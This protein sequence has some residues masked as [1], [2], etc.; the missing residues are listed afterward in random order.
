MIKII[1]N[2]NFGYVNYNK[3]IKMVRPNTSLNRRNN[4]I[5]RDLQSQ[6]SQMSLTSSDTGGSAT[7]STSSSSDTGSSSASASTSSSSDTAGSASASTSSSSDTGGSASAST[8]SSSD[9]GG[10]ASASTSTSSDTASLTCSWTSLRFTG[11]IPNIHPSSIMAIAYSPDGRYVVTDASDRKLRIWRASS[12]R[13][14]TAGL[15][16]EI[17]KENSYSSMHSLSFSGD[18]TKMIFINNDYHNSNNTVEI[19]DI[20]GRASTWQLSRSLNHEFYRVYACALNHDGSIAATASQ[21]MNIRIWNA[22]TGD[23]IRVIEGHINKINCV[24][25]ILNDRYIVSAGL[26]RDIMMWEVET[27]YHFTH[28]RGHTDAVTCLKVNRDGTRLFS[29]S[30]DTTIRMWSLERVPG[31][32]LYTFDCV[33]ILRHHLHFVYALVCNPHFDFVV[34]TSK[35]GTVK[36]WNLS[37]NQLIRT[38]S[39]LNHDHHAMAMSPDGRMILT[40]GIDGSLHAFS[41]DAYLIISGA[42]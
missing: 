1:S 33:G 23:L 5:I 21:D 3:T 19:Y 15:V 37:T 28:M 27:G 31:T 12:F 32:G 17:T 25:F 35:D 10:S 4:A 9:T 16:H 7:A 13:T 34:S 30:K 29:S 41:D 39:V 14:R 40:A 8:S 6:L 2:D 22:N 42:A 26:D 24:S 36:V 20:S 18:G 11:R 38:I